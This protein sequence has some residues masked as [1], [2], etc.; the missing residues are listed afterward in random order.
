M[1]SPS[2]QALLKDNNHLSKQHWRCSSHSLRPILQRPRVRGVLW[3]FSI[4]RQPGMSQR[5]RAT[6]NYIPRL[7]HPAGQPRLSARAGL[8]LPDRVH[9]SRHTPDDGSPGALLRR[10]DLPGSRWPQP[11]A[12]FPIPGRRL[13]CEQLLETQMTPGHSERGDHPKYLVEIEKA[14]PIQH[15]R[16]SCVLV[17]R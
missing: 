4:H 16:R 14:A 13:C 12:I 11:C 5:K 1:H 3:D 6:I 8:K 9:P 17:L 15:D 10:V 7:E 2:S